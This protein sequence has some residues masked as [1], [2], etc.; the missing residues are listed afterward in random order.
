MSNKRQRSTDLDGVPILSAQSRRGYFGDATAI[1]SSNST[2]DPRI[3]L[4]ES[5]GS[6]E[7]TSGAPAWASQ[8]GLSAADVTRQLK[9]CAG[10]YAGKV[11]IIT[12]GARGIGEGCVRC[13]FEAGAN[14]VVADRDAAA[15][16][17][18][19][20][21]L[22]GRD[23]SAA[24][25]ALF[26]KTDVSVVLELERLVERTIERFSKLDC[27]INNAGWHPPH[28]RID[29]FSV[30]DMQNL[31]QLNFISVFALC[32]AALPHL[33][34]TQGNIINISSWV[35]AFGQ[36]KATTCAQ[37]A[38]KARSTP[39]SRCTPHSCGT[40]LPPPRRLLGSKPAVR[41][42]NRL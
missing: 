33:R 2:G 20:A 25:G 9:G 23:A 6:P 41:A 27:V 32:K 34:A 8:L 1:T 22:N 28:K 21:E 17:A 12:G 24:H 37:R 13:F 5:F 35:G 42:S 39:H 11:V 4:H 29:A 19:E 16:R 31:M 36:S 15:G 30:D 18:I 14:V 10:R 38:L 3:V 26:V 40:P 7:S